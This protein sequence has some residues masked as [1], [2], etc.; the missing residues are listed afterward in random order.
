MLRALGEVC[1]LG[2]WN[3]RSGVIKNKA[4]NSAGHLAIMTIC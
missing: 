1:T 3:Y 2:R 4:G